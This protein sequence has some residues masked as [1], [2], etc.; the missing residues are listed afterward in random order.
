MLKSVGASST[1]YMVVSGVSRI[2]RTIDCPDEER[3]RS[4]PTHPVASCDPADTLD[5]GLL[6]SSLLPLHRR[7]AMKTLPCCQGC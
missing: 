5:S 7:L 2:T 6:D 3:L 1:L 4:V